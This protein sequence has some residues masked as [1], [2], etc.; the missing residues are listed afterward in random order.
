MAE[1]KQVDIDLDDAIQEFEGRQSDFTESSAYYR[2]EPRD[3]AVGIATPPQLRKLLAQV[4]IPRVYINAIAERLILEGFL[5]GGQAETDEVLW[6]WYKANQLDSRAFAAFVETLVYGRSYITVSVP[7]KTDLENPLAI[8]DVPIIRLESPLS[9]FAKVDP[10]TLGVEWAVRVTKD[11]N[12]DT[13][14]VTMYYPDRTEVYLYEEGEPSLL[15]TIAHGL[16]VVPV[17]PMTHQ[18]GLTDIYGT[19]AITSEIK[20]V[21]DALSRLMMNMQTT[22]E[23][24]AT[25]QRIIFGSSVDELGGDSMTGLE[26]YTSSYIA[27]EDPQGKAEQLPAA[28]LNNYT[29]AMDHILRQAAIYTGLPPQYLAQSSDNP[30]SAEA[31]MSA[32]NHLVRTCESLAVMLGDAWERAMRIALLITGTKLTLDHFQMESVWRNPATPTYQSMADAATKAYAN[33][34]GPIPL[35]QVRIDM[36]YTPEQ[37]K[38]M[39]EWDKQN[40]MHQMAGIYG[41]TPGDPQGVSDEP[42]P[43]GEPPSK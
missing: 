19:S 41:A 23:L 6:S 24:M 5:L 17:V 1:V 25:P 3:L 13:V 11:E 26:L 15:E 29:Q 4:G 39:A 21:T 36:G 18:V 8:P 40:P 12:G 14:G 34:Q 20:S 2:A 27:V 38:R 7:G 32:E 35:E 30:A 43:D 31:I 37:R 9:L 10:R 42:S 28:E 33:G 22:S 16:G